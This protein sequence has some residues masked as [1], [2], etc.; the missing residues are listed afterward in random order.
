ML[1]H[2]DYL[3]AAREHLPGPLAALVAGYATPST[4]VWLSSSGET[5]CPVAD[6][7]TRDD[8]GPVWQRDP[9]AIGPDCTIYRSDRVPEPWPRT[10]LCKGEIPFMYMPACVWNH[11]LHIYDGRLYLF[12]GETMGPDGESLNSYVYSVSI[13]DPRP[14]WVIDTRLE[15]NRTCCMADGLLYVASPDGSVSV[16][17]LQTEATRVICPPCVGDSSSAGWLVPYPQ[18]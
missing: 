18:S 16:T 17:D 7:W 6:E 11:S 4:R 2:G 13:R 8:T 15:A 3:A 9:V 5:Y 1:S 10:Y 14:R 12:G